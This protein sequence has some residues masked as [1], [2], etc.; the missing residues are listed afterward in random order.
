MI[1]AVKYEQTMRYIVMK[2]PKTFRGLK[3][4][5]NWPMTSGVVLYFLAGG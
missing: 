2:D 3:R 4:G 1:V 5:S